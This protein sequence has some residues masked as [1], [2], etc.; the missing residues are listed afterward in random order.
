MDKWTDF[1]EAY[2]P[3][4]ADAEGF[5]AALEALDLDAPRHRA[6]IMMH[7]VQR[8]VSLADDIAQIRPGKESLQLLFLLICGENIAKLSHDF[9]G[10]GQSRAYVRQF[11]DKFVV[12]ADRH[13][14]EGS[15]VSKDF[16]ALNLLQIVDTL[17]AVR[18]DVVHEGQYWSFEFH[19]GEIPMITGDPPVTVYLQLDDLRDIVVR[20]SI[21]AINAYAAG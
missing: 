19:D 21:R 16:V 6:K 20:G 2:F 3:T 9:Q 4:R 12:G 1:Y 7:Q 13:A 10:D 5:V 14:L 8:L 18:C 11:F 17:Y 15:I